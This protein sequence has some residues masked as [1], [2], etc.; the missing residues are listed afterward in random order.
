M[1]TSITNSFSD[2][3]P[4]LAIES[5]RMAD[6]LKNISPITII[7]KCDNSAVPTNKT[8]YTVPSGR[9]LYIE[10]ARAHQADSGTTYT[11]YDNASDAASGNSFTVFGVIAFTDYPFIHEFKTPI[12]I[13]EGLTVAAAGQTASKNSY[14]YFEGYLV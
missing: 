14:Y 8:I 13:K 2:S 7:L 5:E 1:A 10:K 3:K 4:L 9:T 12:E 11:F 6:G